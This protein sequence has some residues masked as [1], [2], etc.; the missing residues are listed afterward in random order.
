M[1]NRTIAVFVC[2]AALAAAQNSVPRSRD[3][4]AI[5]EL[6]KKDAAASKAGDVDT[7]ATLWTADA[8]ALPPGEEP[9][10][11][12]DAIRA[13][14]NRSRM[15]TTKF[16]ITEYVMDFQELR[17]IGDEAIEWG[18]TRAAMRPKGAPAG[19]HTTGNLMRVLRRQPDGTWKVARAI[20][21]LQRPTPEKP[22]PQR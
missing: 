8:V 21:N 14:L 15:D 10:I 7:L 5:E 12:I 9:V 17:V 1:P 18:R 20:W 13:W 19:M 22:D 16:E 3:M 4:A 6:H 2:L 11:G